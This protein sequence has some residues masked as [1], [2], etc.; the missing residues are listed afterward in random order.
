MLHILAL[1]GGA[2]AVLFLLFVLPALVL[3]GRIAEREEQTLGIRRS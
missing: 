2:G 1:T 3:S